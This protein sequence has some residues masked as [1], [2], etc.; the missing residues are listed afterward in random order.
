[1]SD[2]SGEKTGHSPLRPSVRS[3]RTGASPISEMMTRALS[4]PDLIS[5]AA[6]FVDYE[7]L[8]VAEV[9]E[10][11]DALLAEAG[12]AR[13]ALQYGTTRGLPALRERLVAHIAKLDGFDPGERGY[14]ADR[15]V[16]GT[17]S[18]QLL[19]L[20]CEVLL[21][22]GDIVILGHPSYF[23]FMDALRSAGVTCRTVPLDDEGL[24]VDALATLFDELCS[25]G[26]GERVK[27]LYTVSYFQNPTGLSLSASRRR[28]LVNLVQRAGLPAQPVIVEDAA[29]RE[30]RY[31][32]DDVPSVRS[33]DTTGDRVVYLGTF[34]KPFAPGM[35]LGY[36]LF[37]RELAGRV[38][39]L[40]GAHDFGSSNLVQHL[41]HR[42]LEM[43]LYGKHVA[44]LRESYRRRRDA[45]VAA[46]EREMPDGVRW[47]H[48]AGGLYVW[49]T[50][51]ESV[52]TGPTSTL[53]ETS[54]SKGM[55]YVPG[56]FC[57][58]EDPAVATPHHYIRLSF[59]VGS[60]DRIVEGVTRL[61]EAVR[62]C[63]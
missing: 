62:A 13:A 39:Q 52:E 54:V 55:L 19:Y 20:L 8:P 30:L 42:V 27:L 4:E 6:G 9:R 50:L 2:P 21:D 18:Q 7:T 3:V 25:S 46:L 59:G 37:G 36:G 49:L 44:Q 24:R 1:M 10:A 40:K 12:S 33:L 14:A 51:P 29:Y 61:G 26:Q 11:M 48:P 34:S 16:V 32:G 22:P 31:D 63:L 43:G 17:G 53:F 45:T 58:P 23:V 35:K 38:E 57:F 56:E 28:A 15:M 47:V 41:A 5:L 60:I